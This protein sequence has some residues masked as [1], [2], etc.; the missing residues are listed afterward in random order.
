MRKTI[1]KV[2]VLGAGTMGSRIAA[3]LANAGIR[4]VL[5]DMVPSGSPPSGAARSL[6]A[7]NGLKNAVQAKPAAFFEASL[8]KLVTVGNFDDHLG[9][10]ADCDWIIEAVVEDL[11]IKRDLLAKVAQVRRPGTIVTTNT[12]GL[13]VAKIAEGFPEEFQRHWFGTH[14]FNPPR[15]MRL[16]EI[17]PTAAADAEVMCELAEFCDVR[18][19]KGIVYAHDTPNF[20]ANRI[21]TF[22]LLNAMRLMQQMDLSIEEV[23]ALT[24]NLVGWPK[25]ATFR[26]VDMVGLDIVGHVAA[27]QARICDERSDLAIPDF[28]RQMIERKWLGDKTKG[29]FYRQQRGAGEERQALDWKTVEYRPRQKSAFASLEMA[30]GIDDLGTRVQTLVGNGR[31]KLDKAG[32]FL[33]TALSELWLYSANR[34]PEIADSVAD[35]DRAMR[36]GFNWELGPFELWDAVGVEGTVGRMRAEGRVIPCNVE[37]V[38][39]GER[40]CWYENAPGTRSGRRYFDL[41][42]GEC[43]YKDEEVPVGVGSVTVMKKS[44]GEVKRNA[45]ASLIDLGDGVGCI[46]FHSKMNAIGTDIGQLILQTLGCAKGF[47]SLQ[48][49]AKSNGGDFEAFVIT[50]DAANFSVGANLMLLLMAAQEQEWDEIDRMVR[51]FQSMTQA[52]KFSAKPVVAAP[53]NLTLGGGCEIALHAP[54][55]QS[56]AEL[57]MGLVETGVGLLPAGGGCKEMLLRSLDAASAVR[58]DGRAESVEVVESIKR[59]FETI[60]MAKVATSALEARSLGF[61]LPADTISMNRERVLGDAKRRALEM[62]RGGYQPPTPR[63]EVPAPGEN[64]LATLKLGAYLMRQGDYISD[65]ELKIANR[66]AEVLCGGA[67]SPGT[68]VSEQYLLDLEREHFKALCGEKKTVERIA[69]TL[70]TGKVMRN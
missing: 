52:I 33:W 14:F 30:K 8:A 6:L 29:G 16:L 34:I 54:V 24:G 64:L 1:E 68:P 9:W 36:L 41:A 42:S 40:H 61:L 51:A 43:E 59:A 57:Y 35:I 70:K 19:G 4:C 22:G 44:N 66:I 12:S 20:I 11:A 2:A 32:Q 37:R 63:T 48:S 49:A 62:V 55:R 17:I 65:H 26:T 15:Y 23:D 53:F 50:N 58:R 67:V 69:Y 21:G 25:S 10:L 38:L 5:L 45:G 39:H 31:Q 7:A 18:L 47:E 13:P 46:E 56:H 3:H 27:N 60:A 28:F